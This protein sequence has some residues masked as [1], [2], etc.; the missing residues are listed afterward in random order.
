MCSEVIRV[1]EPWPDRAANGAFGCLKDRNQFLASL[2]AYPP[3]AK[4]PPPEMALIFRTF[5]DAA[6]A[7]CG[8]NHSVAGELPSSSPSQ[9]QTGGASRQHH[10]LLVEDNRLD[11]F[12]VQEALRQ[13]SIRAVLDIVEDGEEA[14]K[15]IDAADTNE[16]A[17][18]LELVLL[19]LNLPKRSGTE[20]LAY[21]RRS[22]RSA[23]AKVLIV[24][25][26]NSPLDRA[27]TEQMG[28]TGYFLKSSDLE[29]FLKIG[30]V[31]E[32]ALRN[33]SDS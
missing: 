22:K 14:V 8:S 10:I 18:R 15:F 11:A 20:V 6:T 19:D 2:N 26:S 24:T 25:S 7:E 13:H 1:H 32:E 27:A 30:E 31:V 9:S 23:K 5:R 12:M 4:V 3:Q 17:P 28:I 16:S 33:Q 21:L 29:E